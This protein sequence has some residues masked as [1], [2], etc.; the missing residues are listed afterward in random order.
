MGSSTGR[1]RSSQVD[2]RGQR[3]SHAVLMAE[4]GADIITLDL[5]AP[6][7]TVE[8]PPATP[9]DLEDTVRLVQK[10]GRRIV[11][12]QADVHDF[13]AVKSVV[14]SGILELGRLDFVVNAGSCR[15]SGRGVDGR[16]PFMMPSR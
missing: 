5:C 16:V 11:A 1:S 8:Y 2:A 4:E 12:R 14:R 9:D 7:G 13:E 10:T 15:Q 3:R 6:V